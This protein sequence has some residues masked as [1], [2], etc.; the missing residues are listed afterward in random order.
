MFCVLRFCSN[1]RSNSDT[2]VLLYISKS[3]ILVVCG[4]KVRL[5]TDFEFSWWLS[6]S[7]TPHSV[8][9]D[10]SLIPGLTQ[11]VKHP[12]LPQAAA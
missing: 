3:F 7:R 4:D 12:A 8:P 1:K 10:A 2:T 6:E 9:E 5:E 11:W